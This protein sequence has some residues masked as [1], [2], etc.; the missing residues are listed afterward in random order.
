MSY[1]QYTEP[2]FNGNILGAIRY[3]VDDTNLM[4]N[5]SLAANDPGAGGLPDL[6]VSQLVPANA[7]N[8]PTS[9]M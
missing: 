5:A 3:G 7:I 8:P 1:M 9:T 6:A 4:P 2:G